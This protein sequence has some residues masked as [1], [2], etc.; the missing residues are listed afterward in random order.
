MQLTQV[1][2]Y[3]LDHSL[4]DLEREHCVNAKTG[5][6][7]FSLNY[8][9][10]LSNEFNTLAMECRGLV[11]ARKDGSAVQTEDE[12][13][14]ETV[15]LAFPMRR[16]FNLGQPSAAN[17]NYLDPD[18]RFFEKED[19]TLI[20]VYHDPFKG[21]WCVA[22]RS[23]CEANLPIDG[24]P[25]LTFRTLFERSVQETTNLSFSDWTNLLVKGWTYCFE[26]TTPLNQVVVAH[27]TFDVFLLTARDLNT[28]LEAPLNKLD[29]IAKSLGVAVPASYNFTNVEDLIA[30]VNSRPGSEFEGVVV[31][32][33]RHNRIKIKS[34]AYSSAARI[35][36]K[37]GATDRNL[38]D[39]I[40]T[41]QADDICPILPKYHQVRLLSMQEHVRKLAAH[42]NACYRDLLGSVDGQYQSPEHRK[43]FAILASQRGHRMGTIMN[44]YTLGTHADFLGA[45]R[46]RAGNGFTTAVLDVVLE[47]IRLIVLK[48]QNQ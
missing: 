21:E 20:I 48:D 26:L 18:L 35:V 41:G 45:L 46:Q 17:I 9:Q 1:Q 14:G 4:A 11:L 30:Y 44:M 40:L 36:S 5:S 24:S 6:Y 29:M 19:G 2:H 34:E 16:F 43:Q 10:I 3:L 7:K 31:C 23:V 38:L 37:M 13:I 15:V 42:Y 47:D 12:I 32:D 25:E 22:T 8:D 27:E 33:S 39:A 28:G